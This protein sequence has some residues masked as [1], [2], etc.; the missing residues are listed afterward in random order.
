MGKC[1]KLINAKTQKL[2]LLSNSFKSSHV[3]VILFRDSKSNSE[4]CGCHFHHHR[5]EHLQTWSLHYYYLHHPSAPTLLCNASLLHADI[6]HRDVCDIDR[7]V[8]L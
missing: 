4:A 7:R 6:H 2:N 3:F 8:C 5:K 1:T